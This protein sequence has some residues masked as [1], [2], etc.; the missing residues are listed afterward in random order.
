[1]KSITSSNINSSVDEFSNDLLQSYGES[2]FIAFNSSK[3]GSCLFNALSLTLY[4]SEIH[5]KELRVKALIE[6]V[7][8]EP[9]IQSR[10]PDDAWKVTRNYQETVLECAS[11][12][13]FSDAFTIMALSSALRIGIYSIYP[14]VNGLTDKAFIIFNGLFSLVAEPKVTVHIMWTHTHSKKR[15]W[16]PNHFVPLVLN[17][18]KSSMQ[19]IQCN[20]SFTSFTLNE[21][22]KTTLVQSNNNVSLPSIYEPHAKLYKFDPAVQIP[23]DIK[24]HDNFDSLN[25]FSSN[26]SHQFQVSFTEPNQTEIKLPSKVENSVDDQ[27][28]LL[29]N[30]PEPSSHY[31]Q[32]TNSNLG[33]SENSFSFC[34]TG[35]FSK[36]SH[37]LPLLLHSQHGLKSIPS[38]PKNNLSFIIENH[39]NLARIKRGEKCRFFD[40]CGQWSNG[41]NKKYI[42]AEINSIFRNVEKKDGKYILK[43]NEILS[44]QPENII[45]LNCYYA[46]LKRE[47]NIKRKIIRIENVLGNLVQA[48]EAIMVSEYIGIF[49]SNFTS[50]K[51]SLKFDSEYVRPEQLQVSFG[52]TNINKSQNKLP[53]A[54]EDSVDNQQMLPLNVSGSN[55][56]DFQMT[57]SNLKE[58]KI[59]NSFSFCNNGHF[60]EL[61]H[62]LPLLLHS[63]HGLKAIPFGPKNNLSF[64]VESPENIARIKRGEKCRFFDDCGQWSHGSNKKYIYAEIDNI[65]K[66]VEKKDGKYFLRR[67]E[68]LNPQ[69][70]NVITLNCYYATLKREEGFKKK[71]IRVESIKGN[72]IQVN[73]VIMVTEYIGI[74][75]SH[76]A[77]HGNSLKFN[78]EYTRTDPQLIDQMREKVKNVNC[79]TVY[80]EEVAKDSIYKPRNLK[81]VHNIK[82]SYR[83]KEQKLGNSNLTDVFKK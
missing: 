40:D 39:D 49:P 15:Y 83:Q 60:S 54:I 31:F 19:V 2:E 37:I 82:Q 46:T 72:L 68:F 44:P 16:T 64:I 75:P 33:E 50:N 26:E 34:N 10:L 63:Q 24:M 9:G 36:L 55:I 5:S 79:K 29:L 45:V 27:Q 6:L 28:M 58:I 66:N 78:S 30:V 47:E 3:D 71:I 7:L 8:N 80:L 25:S 20:S 23:E 38:G 77:P 12:S 35:R 53:S 18:S 13:G 21:P 48:N 62:I 70:E 14:P 74:F 69:P 42:Y 43:S 4:G 32:M 52:E 56:Q 22:D 67:K 65:F 81:Q 17:D 51:N 59:E 57:N 11:N 1:M 73:E 41:S 61:S 76:V